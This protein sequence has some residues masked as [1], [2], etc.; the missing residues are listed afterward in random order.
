MEDETV[1]RIELTYSQLRAVDYACWVLQKEVTQGDMA[2]AL[3]TALTQLQKRE[4][5]SGKK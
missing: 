2:K 4:V 5:V 3:E 1:Y